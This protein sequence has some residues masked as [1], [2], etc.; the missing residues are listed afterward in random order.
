M[1]VGH[2]MNLIYYLVPGMLFSAVTVLSLL[3]HRPLG[4]ATGAMVA[5]YCLVR[6]LS[7]KDGNE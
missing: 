2:S 4:A 7:I 1:D 3:A 5:F 6:C